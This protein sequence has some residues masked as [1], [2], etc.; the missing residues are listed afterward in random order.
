MILGANHVA[1]SVPD[2][3]KAVAFYRDLVGF[4]VVMEFGWEKDTPASDI[5]EKILAVRGTA[6]KMAVLRAGN[7]LLELF[8]FLAG[9]PKPQDSTKPVIDHGITH[10]C[11]AVTDLD[12]E[13]ERLVSGG[14]TFHCP[15]TQIAPGIRTTYG[16]D[17]FGNVLEFEEVQ[18]RT[19]AT[20]S[21]MGDA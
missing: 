12:A 4:P 7:L 21:V 18:G 3:D 16:R 15:P 11:F 14:M 20:Q 13:Y 6:T 9:N 8:Q 2:L 19:S 5:A 1:L 17:P 10:I